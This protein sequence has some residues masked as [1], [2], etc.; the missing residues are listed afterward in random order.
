MNSNNT[1]PVQTK[2]VRDVNNFLF[3]YTLDQS[4]ENLNRLFDHATVG[5][6]FKILNETEKESLLDFL[7]SLEEL[8][9]ALYKKTDENTGIDTI[10]LN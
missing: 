6:K 5:P 10:R 9:P 8:L 4:I 2:S 7:E 3:S 1:L